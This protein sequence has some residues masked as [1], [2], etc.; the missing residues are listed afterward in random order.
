MNARVAQPHGRPAS[1]GMGVN[2]PFACFVAAPPP[3]ALGHAT[4]NT[5]ASTRAPP[6]LAP[7]M[8]PS[9]LSFGRREYATNLPAIASSTSHNY[10]R[11]PAEAEHYRF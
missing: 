8:C 6:I 4:A 2:V 5:N 11:S 10:L 1:S 3:C 9:S 7:S